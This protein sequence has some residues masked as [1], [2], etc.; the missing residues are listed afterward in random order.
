MLIECKQPV[1]RA[2][3]SQW[4]STGLMNSSQEYFQF[5]LDKGMPL[6][7]TNEFIYFLFTWF[8]DTNKCMTQK[9]Q[10]IVLNWEKEKK[11]KEKKG[12][13]NTNRDNPQRYDSIWGLPLVLKLVVWILIVVKLHCCLSFLVCY[14][15]EANTT[16]TWWN[17]R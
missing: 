5:G 14:L 13:K 3:D 17:K 12:R 6:Q 15:S 4:S 1:Q 8:T 7:F 2:D 16:Q 9:E 10:S 11:R